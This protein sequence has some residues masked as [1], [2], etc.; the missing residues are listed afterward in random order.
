MNFYSIKQK[1]LCC[2]EQ[3]MVQITLCVKVFKGKALCFFCVS[4][5]SDPGLGSHDEPVRGI[6]VLLGDFS[7]RKS[8]I[9]IFGD[10]S[11]VAG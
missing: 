11:T 5:S 3:P 2:I 8:G 6:I 1:K 9:F 4:S 10:S 7:S